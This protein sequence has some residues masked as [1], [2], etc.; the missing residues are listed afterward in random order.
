MLQPEHLRSVPATQFTPRR[1]LS[2]GLV[3]LFHVFVI[4]A[5][6][7]GLANRMVEKLPEDIIAKVEPPKLPDIK[8]PPP[9]PPE[10]QKPPPPYVPPPDIVIQQEAAPQTSITVQH[11]AVVPPPPKGIT[12]P[13]LVSGGAKCETSYYPPIA[14]RLSQ[15]GT[16]TVTVH[17]A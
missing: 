13:A 1:I 7:S 5:F 3:A 16:T 6:V 14:Q 8:P 9:P 15:E 4:Y 2:V 10:L 11:T 12:A 17:V